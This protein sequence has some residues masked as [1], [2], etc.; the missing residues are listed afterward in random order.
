MILSSPEAAGRLSLEA[1]L[2]R[3]R[4]VREFAPSELSEREVSQLAWAAQGITEPAQGLRTAPSAGA[5]YPIDV[6]FV[7]R[8]GAHRYV[9][10][11]HALEP[12][13]PGDL[14]PA[15]ARAALAQDWIAEAPLV[16]VITATYARLRGRYGGRAERYAWLEAGHVA[17]N[18]HLQAVALGLASAPVG[19]FDDA[20]VVEVLGLPDGEHPL[21]LLPVGHPRA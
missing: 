17:Q 7:R 2:A 4:S 20:R 1:C 15:L 16:A 5:L 10:E 12:A 8:E 11:A 6:Y 9:P 18:V 3:R 21:Y 14:R 19:A 13:A